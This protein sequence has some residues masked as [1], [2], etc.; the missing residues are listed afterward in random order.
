MTINARNYK[1]K[2][3]TARFLQT[4][5]SGISSTGVN[6]RADVA[7]EA[8]EERTAMEFLG[9]TGQAAN[10]EIFVKGWRILTGSD[11]VTE[12]QAAWMV[13]IAETKDGITDEMVKSLAVRLEQGFAR[14]AAS[15]FITKYKDLPTRA[16]VTARNEAVHPGASDE[17]IKAATVAAGRYALVKDGVT[18]FYRVSLG[19]GQWAGRTFVNAQASD[20]Q[21]PIR[22]TTERERIL[23]EIAVNPAEAAQR[24]GVE[25]GKCSR[26]GRTLTDETSRALGIGPECRKK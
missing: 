5:H 20:E 9:A 15:A 22:N 24:Y 8:D 19:K 2:P 26:C 3:H 16:Q 21:Y 7:V 14:S 6:Y 12:K 23:A 11:L 13:S 17:E 1:K 4:F 10:R 18:K 25:L